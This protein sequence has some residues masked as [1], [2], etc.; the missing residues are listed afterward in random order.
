[1]K[2]HCL[3]C[4]L[5]LSL[6]LVLDLAYAQPPGYPP[7]NPGPGVISLP[8]KYRVVT[9]DVKIGETLKGEKLLG[10]K[11][12]ILLTTEQEGSTKTTSLVP[13]TFV[14]SNEPGVYQGTRRL[15]FLVNREEVAKITQASKTGILSVEVA[16]E[17]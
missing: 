8:D 2:F 1:M 7:P 17:K 10:I 13:V 14:T 6:G 5:L 3:K 16:H 12:Q 15:T 4:W 11:I 9:T